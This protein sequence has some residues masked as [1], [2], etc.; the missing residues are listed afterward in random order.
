MTLGVW[1]LVIAAV[2]AGELL[3]GSSAPLRW[4]S[5]TRINDKVQHFSAYFLLG[6][7]PAFGFERRSGILAALSMIAFGV[8]LEFLQRVVGRDFDVWDMVANSLGV[9]TGIA[10][11]LFLRKRRPGYASGRT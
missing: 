2:S 6:G 11:S 5:Y 9:L 4:V 8:A 3:P 10:V 1:L 7:I